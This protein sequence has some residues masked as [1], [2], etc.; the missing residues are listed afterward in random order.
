M[1][2]QNQV[3]ATTCS[4]TTKNMLQTFIANKAQ[5]QT[6]KKTSPDSNKPAAA[7][8]SSKTSPPQQTSSQPQQTN[9]TPTTTQTST[10][11]ST[12][13][14]QYRYTTALVYDRAMLA[15]ECTCKNPKMH[16]ETSDR[17][18]SIYARLCASGLDHECEL[19][20][21]RVA[22]ITDLLTCHAEQYSLIFGADIEQRA[23]LPKEYLQQYV[24][25]VCMAQCGGFALEQDQDNAWN[26]ENT[27]VA[28]RVAVGSVYEMAR[29][30]YEG[31]IRNGFGLV[32]PP[33]SHA[34][35]NRPLYDIKKNK[36]KTLLFK[37][38][39]L[40]FLFC[41]ILIF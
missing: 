24:M 21:R 38:C 7:V 33:G 3:A 41:F 2:Q 29:L 16:L 23:K 37:Q 10:S 4:S 28:C 8:H 32:R 19:V 39:F 40:I 26:E 20:E 1:S 12:R 6:L 31:K 17:I 25:K 11:P 27:P 22:S 30:V 5:Q 13:Q 14:H 9:T 35:F 15:H 18:E 36:K 34:E